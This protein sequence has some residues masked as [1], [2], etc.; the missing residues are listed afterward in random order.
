MGRQGTGTPLH[1]ASNTNFFYQVDGTKRWYLI[2][3]YDN[4]LAN[5]FMGWGLAAISCIG[6]Y[7]DD[8]KD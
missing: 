4:Y 2:D 6:L 1:A 3:P 5:P 8:Y 7:P